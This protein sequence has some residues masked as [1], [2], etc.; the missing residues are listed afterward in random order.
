MNNSAVSLKNVHKIYSSVVF[1]ALTAHIAFAI[2]FICLKI[3]PLLI[4]NFFSIAFYVVLYIILSPKL[5]TVGTAAVHLEVA[6]FTIVTTIYLGWEPGYF[7]YLIALCSLVYFCPYRNIYIPYYFAFGELLIF[8]ILKIYTF[9]FDAIAPI[10]SPLVIHILYCLNAAACIAVILY[11]AYITNLSAIFAK[12]ELLEKNRNL[13]KLLHHDDLT[14]LY[15]RNYLIE[16]FQKSI[17]S[18]QSAAVIMTDID[19]FKYINDTYGHPC[20]DYVLFTVSTIMKTV[21]HSGV[22]I[23]RWGGEEFILIIYDQS[24][25]EVL[26]SIQN[27][28][29]AIASYDFQFSDHAFQVTATFGISFTHE[30]DNLDDLIH[31]ADERMYHGKQ[32]GKNQ[33]IAD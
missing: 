21:F 2:V 27:L 9:R 24:K 11:A 19:S 30:A 28:R 12:R 6:L 14:N 7:F 29:K 5:Y 23:C 32:S 18:S 15:T 8:L 25:E 1:L 33:V 17:K 13:T 3:Y 16:R 22:D 10:H 26:A 31:L 4:Y 20:G